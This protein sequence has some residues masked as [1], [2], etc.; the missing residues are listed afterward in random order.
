MCAQISMPWDGRT[1][2]DATIA[3]YDSDEFSDYI[4]EMLDYNRA[5]MGVVSIAKTGYSGFLEVTNP[6]GL[7]IRVA[8]GIAIVDGKLYR[9]SA[10]VDNTVVAPGAGSNYYRVILRKS[11][12]AQTVRVALLGPNVVAPPSVTQTD[13]TTWEIGL[14]TVQVTSGSV[15]TVTDTRVMIDAVSASLSVI[16]PKTGSAVV[17]G[18][19][20]TGT[21]HR[22]SV[23]IG[24]AS[25][26]SVDNPNLSDN[27]IIGGSNGNMQATSDNVAIIGG[28]SN[29]GGG[30]ESAIIGGNANVLNISS[31]GPSNCV[32]VGGASNQIDDAIGSVILGGSSNLINSGANYSLICCGSNN[33]ISNNQAHNLVAGSDITTIGEY[34][35]VLGQGHQVDADYSAAFGR[36]AYVRAIG[37]EARASNRFAVTGDAQSSLYVLMRSVTHSSNAWFDLYTTGS[38]GQ[39]PVPT[40]T[41]FVFSVLISGV[42]AGAAKSFGFKIEGVIENDG[43]VTAILGTP[44]VTT[45]YDADD[46]SFDAQA[47]ADDPNNAL[48]IQVRDTDGAGDVVRWV[49][50]VETAEVSFP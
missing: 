16:T 40:D 46:V 32:I 8:T 38:A 31:I 6:A 37:Q 7:T 9:N 49:A 5:I 4:D 41:V 14:A 11:F 24:G 10:S 47:V 18:E 48:L 50:R 43:G 21:L 19:L 3:P 28:V 39:I 35:L 26:I 2:G 12:A 23:I 33:T 13:G 29:T 44:T 17:G 20:H 34:G 22:N 36:Y 25:H 15:V 42:T 45:L 27:A 1:V 30:H